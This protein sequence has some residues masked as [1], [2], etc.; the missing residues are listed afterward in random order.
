MVHIR[1]KQ[2]PSG[3]EK[4]LHE[5]FNFLRR[6]NSNAYIVDLLPDLLLVSL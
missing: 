5:P 2:Y 4:K 6:I 1:P 3:T